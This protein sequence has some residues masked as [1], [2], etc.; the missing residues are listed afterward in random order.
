M[1]E[2]PL[3]EQLVKR[4]FQYSTLGLIAGF[5][6]IA[7]GALLFILGIAGATDWIVK[8]NGFESNLINGAP[9]VFLFLVGLAMVAVTRRGFK[10]AGE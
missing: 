1:D 6:S 9:G 8:S 4:Q 2:Q 7:L 3:N 10:G 5:G